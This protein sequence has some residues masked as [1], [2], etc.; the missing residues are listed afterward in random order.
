MA[1]TEKQPE[2]HQPPGTQQ[3]QNWAQGPGGTQQEYQPPEQKRRA[4]DKS[5]QQEPS[6]SPKRAPEHTPGYEAQQQKKEGKG[7]PGEMQEGEYKDEEDRNTRVK[8][9]GRSQADDAQAQNEA[10]ND[11]RALH[12]QKG[13]RAR[14]AA[15]KQHVK[16]AMP[17]KAKAKAKAR[18]HK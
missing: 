16:R 15:S 9:A 7:K 3:P 13:Q 12:D 4:D 2:G 5:G 14:T 6:A 8:Q 1:N 17:A 18:K 10:R 11:E